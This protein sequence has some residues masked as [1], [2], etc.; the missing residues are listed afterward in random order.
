MLLAALGSIFPKQPPTRLE[1]DYGLG[2]RCS[3]HLNTGIKLKANLPYNGN[4]SHSLVVRFSP[5]SRAAGIVRGKAL[6]FA[7]VASIAPLLRQ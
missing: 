3:I 5:T 6:A 7:A 4:F 2:N 1:W